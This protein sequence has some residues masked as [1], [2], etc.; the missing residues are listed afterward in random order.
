MR[1][2]FPETN[3]HKLVLKRPLYLFIYLLWIFLKLKLCS[4]DYKFNNRKLY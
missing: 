1:E 3:A 4:L 2:L